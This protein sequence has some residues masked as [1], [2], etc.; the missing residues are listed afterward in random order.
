MKLGLGLYRDLLTPEHLRFA[1]QA[2]CTHII[3]HLPGQF[4]RGDEIITSDNADA[5]FGLS[6]ADDPIWSYDGLREL[7]ALVNSE[8]LELEAL[9]N[10]APAHWYDVLLDGP[11]R[12]TQ[13]AHLKEIVRTLGNVGIPTMG[14]CFTLAGVYGRSEG[15]FARGDA[16]SVGFHNP[17]QQPIRGGMVWNMIYDL[18]RFN[19][20][21]PGDVVA[22]VPATEIWRRLEN[23]LDEMIPVAEEAGVNLAFSPR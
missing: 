7:K 19:R 15:P 1:K 22:P 5:G 20:A 11:Q 10:F 8:G 2:G 17:Q 13:M 18:D 4:T 14:Y 23:F 16:K 6:V 9:E 12:D 3:A 21:E